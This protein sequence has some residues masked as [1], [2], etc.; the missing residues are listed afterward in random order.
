MKVV[1]WSWHLVNLAPAFKSKHGTLQISEF[2]SSV[3]LIEKEER[4]KGK[5]QQQN[6]AF[7]KIFWTSNFAIFP[8]SEQWGRREAGP[9]KRNNSRQRKKAQKRL[10]PGRIF[11]TSLLSLCHFFFCCLFTDL[12]S[13]DSLKSEVF[14][15]HM[16][17]YLHFYT[18]M[19][20]T[21][22]ILHIFKPKGRSRDAKESPRCTRCTSHE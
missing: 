7:C 13:S 5:Q 2:I 1:A 19:T 15:D 17:S 11:S 8:P 22:H 18:H 12:N 6:S 9:E 3:S 10:F 16:N 21:L 20:Y 4:R 14:S